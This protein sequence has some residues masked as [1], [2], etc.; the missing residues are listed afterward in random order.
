M[1]SAWRLVGLLSLLALAGGC[2]TTQPLQLDQQPF[3][4]EVR[5]VTASVNTYAVWD[6]YED[7]NDN[8]QYDADEPLSLYCEDTGEVT[9][10]AF[11]A[12]FP[13]TIEISVLRAGQTEAELLTSS[14][15]LNPASNMTLYD[16][17]APVVGLTA[18]KN[19]ITIDDG[20]VMRTFGF[21]NEDRRLV[22][23]AAREVLA[24]TTNPLNDFDP[25]E[26]PLGDGL[27]SSSYPGEPRLDDQ[28]QPW[29]I[30][31]NK[32][33]TLV[34]ELRRGTTA[35]DGITFN[36]NG[37]PRIRAA[38]LLDGREVSVRGETVTTAEPGS[39]IKFSFT[40]I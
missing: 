15:A 33:D 14:A 37:E 34:V 20:G 13:F 30:V 22:S 21:I 35:P 17:A 19:P 27:C 28:P 26:Y 10:S 4:F 9:I 1:R 29:P 12:P 16:D 25:Q 24:A 8:G 32:G 31:L 3:E 40:S 39:G 18:T 5:G 38:L 11:S 23:S 2:D 7:L 36:E 6:M